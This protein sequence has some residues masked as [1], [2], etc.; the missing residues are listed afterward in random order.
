MLSSLCSFWKIQEEL[1]SLPFSP[2]R[3]FPYSL[4]LASYSAFETSNS[5]LNP[6]P[7]MLHQPPL[8]PGL[9][10]LMII[11]GADR[12]SGMTSLSHSQ[13]ISNFNSNHNLNFP[14][15]YKVNICTG[16]HEFRTQTVWGDHYSA[17]HIYI[18]EVEIVADVVDVILN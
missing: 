8:L 5:W 13:G 2:S 1:T 11:L 15:P 17:Y 7:I 14:L 16:S 4:A 9:K 18:Y 6:F 3:G 10:T 12:S